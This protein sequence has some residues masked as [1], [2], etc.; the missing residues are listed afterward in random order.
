[1]VGCEHRSS[2]LS[3]SRPQASLNA[4]IAAQVVEVVAVLIAAGDGE[5]AGAQDVGD[6]VGDQVR[7][8]GGSAIS[9]ASLSAMPRRRSAAAS[10][11]TPPSD[12]R[13]PPS[14]AALTFLRRT[15]GKSNGSRVS[16]DMA[17]VARAMA[18]TAWSRHPIQ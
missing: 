5:D 15:A 12:V 6:A 4:G 7:D 3:G 10:S 8:R 2:P 18:W 16:S 11:I 1:M 13:R 9:A 14:N 17:G